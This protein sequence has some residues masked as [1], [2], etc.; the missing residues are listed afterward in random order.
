MEKTPA[1][2]R[3]TE[4]DR[5]RT[6]GTMA[7][8]TT[9]KTIGAATVLLIG[10]AATAAVVLTQNTA[11]ATTVGSTAAPS[12]ST[13]EPTSAAAS[14]SPTASGTPTT[15]TPTTATP[16]TTYKNGTYS[17]TGSYSSPGGTEQIG[18][19]VTISNDTVTKLALDTSTAQGTA[20]QFQSQFASGIDSLVIGKKLDDVSVSRVS[21]S[22]LTSTGFNEA[23]SS[24]K[25]DA[26]S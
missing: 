17:A 18:V 14:N 19:T 1:A 11:Q 9:K 5:Q 12:A 15:A 16:S 24:I 4:D 26:H 21:G 20:A 6:E 10:G 7:G 13:S 25:S 22:S 2:I 3:S 8:I 23:I